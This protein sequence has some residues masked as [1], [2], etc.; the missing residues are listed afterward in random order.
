MSKYEQLK[1][2]I[3]NNNYEDFM[4]CNS[5]T[6]LFVLVWNIF[7]DECM[8]KR[9]SISKIKDFMEKIK[10]KIT[11]QKFNIEL[12]EY[13]KERYKNG[14]IKGLHWRDEN[15]T[16]LN[17]K[18][19]IEKCFNANK[20]STILKKIKCCLAICFRFRNNLFHGEKDIF[21]TDQ[22]QNFEL[23]NKFLMQ[24]IEINSRA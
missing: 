20:E 13:F 22:E 19:D 5:Q 10:Y 1:N 23:I 11:E 16:E 2:I 9:A 3:D 8:G 18:M 15:K 6:L 21:N 12:F 7:E 14:G 17:L 4:R 24:I